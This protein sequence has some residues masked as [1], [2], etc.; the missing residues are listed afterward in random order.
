MIVYLIEFPIWI[1]KAETEVRRGSLSSFL[2]LSHKREVK[3]SKYYGE[4]LNWP[5]EQGKIILHISLST[6]LIAHASCVSQLSRTRETL[7]EAPTAHFLTC[8]LGYNCTKC[9]F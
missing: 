9:H 5:M 6:G 7:R 3:F 2:G 1:S 4:Q 8:L